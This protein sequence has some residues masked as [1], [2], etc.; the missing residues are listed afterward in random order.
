IVR[1]QKGRI[2]FNTVDQYQRA[3]AL[4]NRGGAPHV[5]GRRPCRLT[6]FEGKIQVGYGSLQCLRHVR[7]GPVFEY[8]TAN[9]LHS[10]RKVYLFL[11]SIAYHDNFFNVADEGWH[12]HTDGIFLSQ[13]DYLSFV[14]DNRKL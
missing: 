1:I 8:F 9:R 10:A 13:L 11:L 3:P 12:R 6:V 14:S 7:R 2:A 4:T 5:E